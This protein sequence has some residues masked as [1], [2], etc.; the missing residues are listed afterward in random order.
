[1]SFVETVVADARKAA[2]I[3]DPIFSF[4]LLTLKILGV[5]GP[6]G[7]I[8]TILQAAAASLEGAAAGAQSSDQVLAHLAE[9][10]AALA[11][12]VTTA[13]VVL[14]AAAAALVVRFGPVVI[15]AAP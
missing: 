11:G 9:I 10:Q 4:A 14:D 8:V 12:N 1:M 6:A 13:Q 2:P 7:E 5:G 3:I 15:P